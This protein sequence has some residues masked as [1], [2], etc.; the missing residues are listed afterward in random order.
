M[1]ADSGKRKQ[2]VWEIKRKL[3]EDSARPIIFYPV[4]GACWKPQFKGHTMMVT[5]TTMAAASKTPGSTNSY[6]G[7]KRAI[8]R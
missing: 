3:A 2:I 1:E 7:G 6:C 4:S 8:G 5:A